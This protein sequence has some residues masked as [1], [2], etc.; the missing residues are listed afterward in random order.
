MALVISRRRAAPSPVL[1]VSWAASGLSGALA[2]LLRPCGLDL[3]RSGRSCSRSARRSGGPEDLQAAR[4][5]LAGAAGVLG[6]LRPLTL[7]RCCCG[8]VA[9]I[10]P[11]AGA[12]APDQRG[13]AVALVIFRRRTVRPLA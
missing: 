1:R 4:C 7:W 9:S 5:A 13:A 6:G 8:P 2:A 11:G 10:T 12:A 3:A